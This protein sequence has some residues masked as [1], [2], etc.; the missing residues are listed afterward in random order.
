MPY[1]DNQGIRIHYQVEGGKAPRLYCSMDAPKACRT[2]LWRAML[3]PSNMP[4][5]AFSLMRV[6]MAA[7]R[8]CR[9]VRPLRGP[10]QSMM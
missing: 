1:A 9:S 8:S 2:G 6:D 10:Y 4:I 7:A 5:N 3:M